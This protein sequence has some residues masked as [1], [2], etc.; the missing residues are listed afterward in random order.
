MGRA[1]DTPD[2][3]RSPGVAPVN[4]RFERRSWTSGAGE[5]MRTKRA[6][7]GAVLTSSLLSAGTQTSAVALAGMP[8]VRRRPP[9]I[10][11]QLEETVPR[12]VSTL[13][14]ALLRPLVSGC[15]L[16]RS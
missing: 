9:G 8:T 14:R 3:L 15:I 4:R 7:D 10:L 5:A 13:A 1:S 2:S 11:I 6:P 12:T 16:T